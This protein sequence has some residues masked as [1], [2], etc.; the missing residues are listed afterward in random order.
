[1]CENESVSVCI[2]C[3]PI[4][5]DADVNLT[6]RLR[7]LG[8]GLVSKSYPTAERAGAI[9][10]KTAAVEEWCRGTIRGAAASVQKTS[11]RCTSPS[12]RRGV[13]KDDASSPLSRG[14]LQRCIFLSSIRLYLLQYR[15]LSTRTQ[16]YVER[17]MSTRVLRKN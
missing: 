4:E 7:F 6:S 17:A 10:H 1:M 14:I 2:A 3:E 9:N 13:Q 16:V 12:R 11:R 5:A 15:S 8:F